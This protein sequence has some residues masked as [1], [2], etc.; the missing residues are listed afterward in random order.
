MRTRLSG[1]VAG[2]AGETR[3][4]YAD[5]PV[6]SCRDP[7][8]G[9]ARQLKPATLSSLMVDTW[10]FPDPE[11]LATFTVGPI[12]AGERHILFVSHEV[13][14]GSWQFLTGDEVGPG[15]IMLVCLADV[16]KTD[17]TL[18]ELSDLPLGWYAERRARGAPWTRQPTFPTDWD[19][20][21]AQ[22][23]AYTAN[24]QDR[25]ESAFSLLDWE[26]YDYNQE[27]ASLLFSSGGIPRVTARIRIVGS[28]A[29]GPR[30]W[31]WAWDNASILPGAAEGVHLLSTFGKQHH[32]TRLST[33]LWQADEVDGWEMTSVACLLFEGDGVYR[34]PDE[35]GALFMVLS[36]PQFVAS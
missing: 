31:L 19:E 32:F 5:T 9:R 34:A 12:L 15:E 21:V 28:W 22:A 1:G 11:N 3:R 17:D 33:A 6:Y 27:S 26:R 7:H 24:C 35:N 14:D 36:D 29:A 10:A 8:F 4:P 18:T 2:I 13:S 30:T 20:L 23:Q 25:L 16:V